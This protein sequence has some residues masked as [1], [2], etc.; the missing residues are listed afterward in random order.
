MQSHKTSRLTHVYEVAQGSTIK[1]ISKKIYLK[2]LVLV[3]LSH[4]EEICYVL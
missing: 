1:Y 4:E 3:Q 2:V